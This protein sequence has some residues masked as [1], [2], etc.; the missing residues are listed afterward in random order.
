MRNL[1]QKF[2]S[3]SST[4]TSGLYATH[5]EITSDTVTSDAPRPFITFAQNFEDVMLWRALKD[6]KNGFYIDVGAHDPEV[7]SVTAAFYARGWRGINVEPVRELFDRLTLARSQDVNLRLCVG[8]ERGRRAFYAFPETGLSTLDSTHVEDFKA[9][10]FNLREEQVEVCSLAEI[11]QLHAPG[12]IHFLKVDVEGAEREVL[13]G[14]DFTIYRPWIVLL[15]ATAPLSQRLVHEEWESIMLAAHYEFVWF[16]GL[17]RFY[18]ATERVASLK[19]HFQSPP[20]VFD[21]FKVRPEH[22][23]AP[24]T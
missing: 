7:H 10:G 3:S 12:S 19:P 9:H 22:F 20:N 2:R 15:E 23:S 24:P 16:D 8:E 11:C 13:S 21:G 5:D 6:V 17:N 18:I 4:T 1:F 14:A